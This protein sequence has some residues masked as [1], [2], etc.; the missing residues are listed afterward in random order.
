[1]LEG[2]ASDRVRSFHDGARSIF[3][4]LSL[5]RGA[6]RSIAKSHTVLVDG[7]AGSRIQR[8]ET[9]AI[10]IIK[11]VSNTSSTMPDIGRYSRSDSLSLSLSLSLSRGQ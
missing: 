5:D 9:L 3:L 6:Y 7:E 8:S 4:S 10:E 11:D 1:M 2:P